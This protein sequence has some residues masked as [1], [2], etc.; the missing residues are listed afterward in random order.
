VSSLLWIRKASCRWWKA[1]DSAGE[2]GLGVDE[3]M[4][5]SNYK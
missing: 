4:S 5:S 1:T 2:F 3:I